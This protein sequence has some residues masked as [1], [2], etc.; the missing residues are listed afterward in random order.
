MKKQK[1][2]LISFVGS[3]DAGKQNGG[4]DGAILTALANQKFDEAILLW[5]Q[6]KRSQNDFKKITSYLRAEIKKRKFARDVRTIELMIS[7]VTDHNKIYETLKTFCDGLDK[8]SSKKYTA[9]ISS[10]TPA[11]QVCWI[12]LAESGDFSKT[13]PLNLIKVTDPK[14]GESKNVIV[15]IDTSLPKIIRLEEENA[16][17]KENLL[18]SITIKINEGKVSIGKDEIDFS[19]IQFCYYRYFTEL[20]VEG[21]SPEKF[22]ALETPAHFV[23]KIF[24]YHEESFPVL[25]VAR[26]ELRKLLNRN[27][28]I[29]RATFNANISKV[30][31]K[32]RSVIQNED[33]LNYFEISAKGVR[34]AKFYGIDM[35]AEKVTIK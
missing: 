2:I 27:L 6:S 33:L 32:I 7:D 5:N 11:M 24:N 35:P 29:A 21:T 34:G 26:E 8:S 17:L 20:I 28:G 16:Q 4:G 15:K 14:F 12:L 18:P 19:P 23:E 3:N 22:S 9:A 25:D 10:G 31:G 30:N 1:E 13:N